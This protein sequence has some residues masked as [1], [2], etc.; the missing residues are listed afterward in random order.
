M[1][2][3]LASVMAGKRSFPLKIGTG[4]TLKKISKT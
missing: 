3:T 4:Q 1:M 2:E